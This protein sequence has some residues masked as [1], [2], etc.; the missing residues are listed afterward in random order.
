MTDDSKGLIWNCETQKIYDI[1]GDLR[2]ETQDGHNSQVQRFL[3]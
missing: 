2:D 3:P 1:G